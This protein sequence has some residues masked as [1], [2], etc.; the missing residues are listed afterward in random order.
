[1]PGKVRL[2]ERDLY[3]ISIWYNRSQRTYLYWPIS[4]P[5]SR[6]EMLVIDLCTERFRGGI[7]RFAFAIVGQKVVEAPTIVAQLF[8]VVEILPVVAS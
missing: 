2:A 8:P 6:V 7:V 1:M 4:T 5:E 3:I